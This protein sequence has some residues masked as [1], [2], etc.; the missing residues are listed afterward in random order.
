MNMLI[1]KKFFISYAKNI[2]FRKLF[3]QSQ[4]ALIKMLT[5]Q[6][7]L[8]IVLCRKPMSF[9]GA[10]YITR[11]TPPLECHLHQRSI[12]QQTCLCSVIDVI[13]IL[14]FNTNKDK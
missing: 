13:F 6:K 10:N 3:P 8:Y 2:I 11:Q 9:F 5:C 1:F 7:F 12:K 4:Y 14:L